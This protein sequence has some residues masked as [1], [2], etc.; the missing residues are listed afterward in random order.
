MALLLVC[1]SVSCNSDRPE[2]ADVALSPDGPHLRITRTATHPFLSRYKLILLVERPGHCSASTELFPDT[3]YASRRNVYRHPSGDISVVGLY[4]VRQIDARTCAV[5]LVEF[6]EWD[7]RALYLG[8]FDVDQENR[9]QFISS[10]VRRE[11]R[12]E[13]H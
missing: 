6:R 5:R 3:G 9:W 1:L 7:P 12:F 2:P 8:V 13:M 11:Q 4:D 10:A